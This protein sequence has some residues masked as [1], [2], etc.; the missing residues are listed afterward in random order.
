[1]VT[2][3]G[4]PDLF[5]TM[6][7]S[8]KWREIQ[9]NLSPGQV[10]P[11]RPDLIA[12]VFNMKVVFFDIEERLWRMGRYIDD[13]IKRPEN[14]IAIESI[15]I[16]DNV[17]SASSVVCTSWTGIASTLLPKERTSA[18]LFKLNISNDYKTSS[19]QRNTK[20]SKKLQNVDVIIW[21]ICSQIPANALEAVD[22]LLRDL[23]SN[24][25]YF[26]GK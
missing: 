4:E 3:F 11:D 10:P 13:L 1:M 5:I 6:T 22:I 24:E 20:D 21:N 7:C 17:K 9:E 14:F 23:C 12:R 15:D 16:T 18:S 26:G 8:P 19:H 2:K 25:K